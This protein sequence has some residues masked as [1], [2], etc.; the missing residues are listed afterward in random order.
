M[1]ALLEEVRQAFALPAPGVA[2]QIRE[3]AGV[4][5]ARLAAEIGVHEIT[6]QRWETGLHAP[7]GDVRRVYARLLADLDQVTRDSQGRSAA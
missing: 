7:H 1:S 2:R 4:S 3:A 5:R 6:V